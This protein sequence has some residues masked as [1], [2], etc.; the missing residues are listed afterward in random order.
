M[1]HVGAY[2]L[3]LDASDAHQLEEVVAQRGGEA[4]EDPTSGR[5]LRLRAGEDERE[6]VGV[7]VAVQLVEA[8]NL[9]VEQP[10]VGAEAEVTER[11]QDQQVGD[12]EAAEVLLEQVLDV[13]AFVSVREKQNAELAHHDQDRHQR[14]QDCE[15]G[16]HARRDTRLPQPP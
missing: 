11:D 2:L 8:P 4:R 3:E 13:R 1:G 7:L 6:G 15:H 12:T 5:T 9:E 10:V 14:A 16:E